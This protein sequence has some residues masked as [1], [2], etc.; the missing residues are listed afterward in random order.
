MHSHYLKTSLIHHALHKKPLKRLSPKVI[1]RLLLPVSRQ[2]CLSKIFASFREDMVGHC[3]E[4][5]WL[6]SYRNL[7]WPWTSQLDLRMLSSQL[8]SSNGKTLKHNSRY[9]PRVYIQFTWAKQFSFMDSLAIQ[10]P[11]LRH[12]A[13]QKREWKIIEIKNIFDIYLKSQKLAFLVNI[14]QAIT[15]KHKLK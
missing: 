3:G 11:A 8:V 13:A 5:K 15:K 14:T 1:D 7:H 9:G 6:Q 4:K 10:L 2:R 12:Q